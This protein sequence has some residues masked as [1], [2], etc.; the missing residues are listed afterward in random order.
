M[1]AWQLVLFMAATS[2]GYFVVQ[3]DVSIVN[4]SLPA[5]RDYYRVD[6]AVLQWIVNLYTLSFSVALLSAGVLGDRFGSRKFL[7]VGYAVFALGS[8]AC[9]VAPSV[10]MLLAARFLQGIGAAI[11]VPNSLAAINWEFADNPRLR[12][13]LVSIWVA[14]GGA[15]LTCGPIFGGIINAFASWRYIFFLNLPACAIGIL[16]T[17]RRVAP[18]PLREARKQDWLG[19]VVLLAFSSTLLLLIINYSDFSPLARFGLL[20]AAGAGMGFF[21]RIEQRQM[22]PAIPLELFKDIGLQKALTYGALVNFAYFGIVFFASLYFRYD[23][24]MSVLEAGLSFIPITLPLIVSTLLSGRI[25]RTHGPERAIAIGFAL[26]IPGLFFLAIPALRSD[27]WL[28][29]PAFALTTL[30]IGFVPPMITAIAIQSIGPEHGGLISSVV[31]FFRQIF[32]AFGVAVF[33][34]FMKSTRDFASYRYF[35]MTL[36]VVAFVLMGCIASFAIREARAR[37]IDAPAAGT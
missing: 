8:L 24:K 23:L 37:R 32:G 3:L 20:I 6:V 36:L 33:G 22:Y 34:I 17:L 12:V 10:S 18:T 26:M 31:N 15:A 2:L 28:M 30:G 19:Q 35:C 1:S 27:Y 5:L 29:L 14:F 13:G 7:L 4:L 21:I 16:L 25:G 9:G 11:I